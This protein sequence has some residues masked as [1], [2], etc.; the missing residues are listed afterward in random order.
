MTERPHKPCPYEDC[1]SSDAFSYNTEGFGFCHACHTK[2]PSNKPM[3]DW[4]KEEYPVKETTKKE[5]REVASVTYEGIRGIQPDVA[6][7]YG[8]QL[9]LDADGEPIQYAFRYPKNT[10]YLDVERP[11]GKKKIWM[12]NKSVK[13]N[14]FFGPEFNAGS[15]K[16]IY[17][18]EGEFDAASLYQALG[19]SL[20]VVSMP[21]SSISEDFLKKTYPYLSKFEQIIYAGELDDPGKRSAEKLYN[22]YPDK[23][24]Y[25][26][27]TKWKDANEFIENGDSEDL[28]WAALK[29]QRYT[30]DNFFCSEVEFD[31]ILREENPYEYLPIGHEG[32]DYMIR[33]LVRGGLTFIKAPPGTGKTELVR[34]FER[35]V[36]QNDRKLGLIHMEEMKSFTL[37]AMAT[38]ELGVNVRTKEDA[39]ENGIDEEKVIEAA[40]KAAGGDNTIIF[41]MRSHDEP[42]EIIEYCRLAASVYGAEFIFIDHIQRLV[43]KGGVE[44]A[45]SNLTRI[46]SN[47]AELAK[48]LDIGIIAIS[49]LNEDGHTKYAKSLEEEAIICIKIERNKEAEDEREKNTT[50]FYIEKNRPFSRLGH[51]GKV[52]Y[53]PQSTILEEVKYDV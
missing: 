43:Y 28:K 48:E 29:P 13:N 25:V 11:D 8:I 44:N 47:L 49:H 15:S 53:D 51:A 5:K 42:V 19:C 10:K 33:G 6:K 14:D 9:Q 4:A 36:L 7:L 20:P 18:T 26:P 45:T 1:G 23:F 46:A 16:K 35:A 32:L 2:Y 40:K 12:K 50:D 24:F 34:Y 17:I 38:Y 31:K 39:V 37:R 30:P 52:Y 3:F 21:S 22:I 27:L 41:E